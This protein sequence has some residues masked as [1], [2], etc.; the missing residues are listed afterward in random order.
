MSCSYKNSSLFF[1]GGGSKIATRKKNRDRFPREI[2][3]AVTLLQLE[4]SR[5]QSV[6]YFFLGGQQ[7]E[8]SVTS[9]GQGEPFSV[10]HGTLGRARVYIYRTLREPRPESCDRRPS[11]SGHR[12]VQPQ[13]RAAQGA[14]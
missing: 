4:L 10:P 6:F 14:V 5:V 13:L 9:V 7:E 2:N 3:G 1:Q 12:L 8:L 11:R